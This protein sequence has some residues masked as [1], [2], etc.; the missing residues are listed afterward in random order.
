MRRLHTRGNSDIT[1]NL[2]SLIDVTF[3]L[4]VFFVLVSRIV[5]DESIDLDLP[6]PTD[7]ASARA[8]KEQQVVINVVPGAGGDALGYHMGGATLPSGDAGRAA[9]TDRLAALYLANPALSIN[10]RADRSTHY[11]HVQPVLDAVSAAADRAAAAGVAPRV[12][13]VV[14]RPN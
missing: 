11:A 12:N 3:L 14:V 1:A 5:E 2:T 7:P 6:R 4:I 8:G 10:L 13:L 9:I